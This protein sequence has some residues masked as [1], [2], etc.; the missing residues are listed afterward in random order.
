M[1]RVND[2]TVDWMASD[3]GL[4]YFSHP[5]PQVHLVHLVVLGS[6]VLLLLILPGM[7]RMS[8]PHVDAV[9]VK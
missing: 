6:L 4:R 2:A 5:I 3:G 7:Y 9:F 8:L 1:N